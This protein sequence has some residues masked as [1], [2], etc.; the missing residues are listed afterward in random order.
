M[1]PR[2]VRLILD[3]ETDVSLPILRC[4]SCYYAIMVMGE[5]DFT[6]KFVVLRAGAEIVEPWDVKEGEV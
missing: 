6:H 5:G 2:R 1:K 4:A 3:V